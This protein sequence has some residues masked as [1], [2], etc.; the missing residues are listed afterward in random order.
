M[1]ADNNNDNDNSNNNDNYDA[2]S[3]D[4]AANAPVSEKAASTAQKLSA[5]TASSIR[6]TEKQPV[7][8]RI[9]HVPVVNSIH[10]KP[11]EVSAAFLEACADSEASLRG[12]DLFSSTQPLI[13]FDHFTVKKVHLSG[14]Q[15]WVEVQIDELVSTTGGKTE[16]RKHSEHQRWPLIH[17]SRTEWELTQPSDTIYLPQK[18]AAHLLAQQLAQLTGDNRNPD[19]PQ[20]KSELAQLLNTLLQK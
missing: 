5:D 14:S 16:T 7:D 2:E 19:G 11:E 17:L 10:P 20:K 18:I 9:P 1:D 4:T 8:S 13:V 6:R 3:A 15:N 12:H